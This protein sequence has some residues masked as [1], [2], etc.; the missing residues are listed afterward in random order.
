M[1]GAAGEVQRLTNTPAS[2]L[3]GGRTLR[4]ESERRG[5]ISWSLIDTFWFAR[6]ERPTALPRGCCVIGMA[7]AG[8]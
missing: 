2:G 8:W 5:P 4:R 1:G 3:G 6:A 7:E